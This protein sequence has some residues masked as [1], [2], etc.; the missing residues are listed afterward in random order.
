MPGVRL[1]PFELREV[2]RMGAA[3]FPVFEQELPGI[4]ATS[5]SGKALSR[6][7]PE[8]QQIASRLGV[9][10][11][12][13]F[14]GADDAALADEVLDGEE[15]QAGGLEL[16]SAR[17]FEAS[18]GLSTVSGLLQYLE[19]NPGGVGDVDAVTTDLRAMERALVEAERANVKWHLEVDF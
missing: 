5:V 15:F 12:M 1:L 10:P 2:L 14:Y 17:W 19:E 7:E 18:D 3:L 8:L 9:T 13:Q 11:L 6:A 4:D 16:P